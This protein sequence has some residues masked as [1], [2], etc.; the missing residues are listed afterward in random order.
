MKLFVA[1][2]LSALALLGCSMEPTYQKPEVKTDATFSE[3]FWTEA[4]P[5][6]AEVPDTWWEVF[7]DPVLSDLEKQVSVSNENLLNNLAQLRG[8]QGTLDA[9]VA[10]LY[11][12]FGG[13]ASATKARNAITTSPSGASQVNASLLK[14]FTLSGSFSWDLDLWGRLASTVHEN[15]SAVQATAETLAAVRL[16]EQISLAQT[17]FALRTAEANMATLRQTVESN[18]VFLSLTQKR[19]QSGVAGSADVAAAE[20]QLQSS[21]AQLLDQEILR[22]QD[23][24][25]IAVLMGQQPAQLHLEFTGQLPKAPALPALL[26]TTLLQR[27]PDIV[28]AERRVA[29]ANA[30]VGVAKAALFPDISLNGS[31]GFRG[32]LM[33]KLLHS[34]QEFWSVGPAVSFSG[35]NLK[36]YDAVSEEALGNVDQALSTYRQTVLSAFQEVEDNLVA[37]RQLEKEE[38]AQFLAWQ[39]TKLTLK[40]TQAQYKAGTQSLLNVITA[41]NNA[42]VAE[43]TW[44][45]VRNRQL[46]AIGVLLKN[47]AGPWDEKNLPPVNPS[48]LGEPPSQ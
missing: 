22:A 26:P 12:T 17:Y 7:H 41:Q 6:L 24:H 28:S 15:E 33:P 13:T 11:P 42:L 4:Q 20:A 19:Y 37:A 5:Q 30:A 36:L 16:A 9:S 40:D 48:S 39:A 2:T 44:I 34:S 47:A 35:V 14:T 1:V 29:A 8:A 45:A 43:N 10:S 18:R 31:G 25:A 38:K 46:V 21:Q 32:G 3:G 23:A 27:R